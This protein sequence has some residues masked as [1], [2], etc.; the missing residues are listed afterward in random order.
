MY[1]SVHSIEY[2][3]KH[4]LITPEINLVVEDGID[5][6][7]LERFEETLNL[8]KIKYKISNKIISGKT[9]VLIGLKDNKDTFVDDYLKSK[10]LMP[11]TD[12]MNKIDSYVLNSKDNVI[13]IYASGEDASY[14]GVTSLWHIFNQ[15][16]GLEIEEFNI[17][18]YADIK[19]RGAIEGYYG[20]PRSLQDRLNYMR[21]GSYY[22]LNGYF[23]AP[24]D[25]PK[26]SHKWRELYTESEIENL[27]KPLAREGNR[28]KVRYIYTLHPFFGTRL[29]NDYDQGVKDLKNKFLQVI[30]AG[31]R[32]IGI[33]ADDVARADIRTQVRL[34]IDMVT[35]LKELKQTKYH[36]LKVVLPFVVNEYAGYG[37]SYFKKFPNEVQIVMTGGKTWGEVSPEF[38]NKFYTNTNRGPLLWINWPCS[39]NSK[40]HLILGGYREFL[41]KNVD[42]KKVQGIVLNP[43]QQSEPSK[44]ALFGAAD[45]TWNIW[46]DD[47][48]IDQTY[49]DAFN[50]VTNNSYQETAESKAFRNL[51]K[52]MINQ[53][54]DGRVVALEESIELKKKLA[55]VRTSLET[56]NFLVDN[57]KD[58]KVEFEEL[59]NDALTIKNSVVNRDLYYQ[60]RYWIES[61]IELYQ[62]LTLALD[63]LIK[64]SQGDKTDFVL[65]LN[66]AKTLIQ[67]ARTQHGFD[68]LGSIQY[69]EVGVQHIQPFTT[70]LLDYMS[71]KILNTNIKN[72]NN[73]KDQVVGYNLEIAKHSS[74]N[75][76]AKNN[77]LDY[78]ID[79]NDSTLAWLS[80]ANNGNVGKDQGIEIHFES[81]KEIKS[82]RILQDSNDK[83]ESLKIQK[84]YNNQVIDLENGTLDFKDKKEITYTV[85]E[86]AGLMTGI[87]ITS[88]KQTSTWWKVKSV[89]IQEKNVPDPS[90]IHTSLKDKSK[91]QALRSNGSMI[92]SN[93]LKNISKN[94]EIPSKGYIG[95]D[96]KDIKYITNIN[97]DWIKNDKF[98]FLISVNGFNWIELDQAN[99]NKKVKFRYLR[100]VNSSD[101]IQIL[102]FTK[103]SLNIIDEIVP[104]G[105]L[106]ETNIDLKN[107][108]LDDRKNGGGFD[109]DFNRYTKFGG[110]PLKG[111]YAI[112][113]LGGE[114]DLK[115]LRMYTADNTADFPRYLDIQVSNQKD[116]GYETVFSINDSADSRDITPGQGGF[117]NPDSLHP[118]LRWWGNDDIKDKKVRY[119]KLL[120]KKDYPSR[121]II[122]NEI[123]VNGGKYLN[124]NIDPRFD[125]TNYLESN[126]KYKPENIFDNKLNSSYKPAEKNGKLIINLDAAR[127]ANKDIKIITEEEPSNAVVKAIV[128]D[129]KT[130]KELEIVI[131][132][133]SN[134]IVSFSLPNDPEKK[135][136]ALKIEWK[137]HIPVISEIID[138]EKQNGQKVDKSKL[139]TLLEKPVVDLEKWTTSSRQNYIA[140]KQSAQAINDLTSVT[141]E[142][143]ADALKALD[144]A[145]NEHK[146]KVDKSEFDALIKNENLKNDH[147]IYTNESFYDYQLA[148]EKIKY[149]NVDDLGQSE[150]NKLK[151]N[152]ETKKIALE[153]SPYNM[154]ISL[155]N[156]E[157]F[158]EINK[159]NYLSDSYNKLKAKVDEIKRKI[160]EN[161]IEPS[162]YIK[163]NKEYEILYS[164]LS[165]K[166]K[167]VLILTYEK[168]KNDVVIPFIAKYKNK[169]PEEYA[170]INDVLTKNEGKVSDQSTDLSINEAINDLKNVAGSI[171]EGVARKQK[172]IRDIYINRKTNAY[173]V[174]QDDKYTNYD[175]FISELA[176]M[177]NIQKT[178]LVKNIMK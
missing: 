7:V 20:N 36:D 113:D 158:N 132:A 62:G 3:N 120:V 69:A 169:W 74:I 23:Y 34:L 54:M 102:K 53:N 95:V 109:G 79:H 24:K 87:R 26:H 96:L 38:T 14:Y 122:I 4:F 10:N 105:K 35:W 90:Y 52:H 75:D 116:S 46:K 161:K 91:L 138:I 17:N 37:Q 33:L 155:F 130:N 11:N 127:Y 48:H 174:Y 178:W 135:V 115:S 66:K 30:Q 86:N 45:Y 15:L 49:S 129:I 125:G 149:Q 59:Y 117:G 98:K 99:F 18:D 156:V 31:V 106:I 100:L 177:N 78:I 168:Y 47:A 82:I 110:S 12:L 27:I 43:M 67:K 8:R 94:H 55:K 173:L 152:L 39:D 77:K 128:Y 25:D 76:N 58:L 145:I 5:S 151:E 114:L 81:A 154:Q 60:I 148:L 133:L 32:Q 44:V 85:P 108:W 13:S 57:I 51:A 92:L 166:A 89:D 19:T 160:T 121:A 50:Y 84:L 107:N 22:K 159:D 40:N 124:L 134:P 164:Q 170:K 68:Y 21:W 146:L 167:S 147:F 157:K 101:A 104:F 112:Y 165:P 83:M 140:K 28:T 80:S 153:F 111:Q 72:N 137:D 16:N 136:V 141:Q 61:S 172:E 175:K 64:L 123:V 6:A 88:T 126:G 71:N 119:I 176:F 162:E 131:G 144:D 65:N 171:I 73:K 42:P 142:A 56:N 9:N 103:L 41:H 63:G 143:V 163:L 139:K 150:F 70:W 118:N 2:Y 97:I 1:P 29:D 93:D